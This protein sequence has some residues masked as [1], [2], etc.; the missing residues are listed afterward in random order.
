MSFTESTFK[1]HAFGLRNVNKESV[2][3]RCLI[4]KKI[5][6]WSSEKIL[7]HSK[8]NTCENTFFIEYNQWLLMSVVKH[9]VICSA[10]T[11]Y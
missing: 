11:G 7:Q 9:Q 4:K 8:E 3:S 5:F 1:D 6:N 2:A 10:Y